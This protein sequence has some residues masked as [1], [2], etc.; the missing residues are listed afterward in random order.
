MNSYLE[1][2]KAVD[3][4][5]FNLSYHQKRYDAVLESLKAI[6]KDDLGKYLNPPEYGVY[7]CRLVYTAESIEVTYHEYKKREINSLKIVFDNDIEY[8][9]KFTCRNKID[10]LFETREEADD[11]LIVK[12]LLVRDTS[13]ANIAFYDNGVW[14]TPKSPL[15]KGTTRDRLLDEGKLTEADIKIQDIR[16]YKKVA[17]MN[18]MIDFYVLE[19]CEFLI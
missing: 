9:N 1:T 18:A 17:L 19:N 4:E 7:R 2:I 16:K 15:L 6:E 11:I 5:I 12:D 8:A 10:A 14:L 13:I 3:G